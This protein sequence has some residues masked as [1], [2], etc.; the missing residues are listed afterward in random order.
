MKDDDF[1]VSQPFLFGE[2]FGE[3]AK[4][5]LEAA[6]ALKKAVNPLVKKTKMGFWASHPQQYN[7][8][9]QGGKQ[10]HYYSSNK[11]KKYNQGPRSQKEK[12]L[13]K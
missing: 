10:T 7:R 9:H 12:C 3:K 4:V 5:K 8:G 13:P 1:K 2:N 11:P 6:A